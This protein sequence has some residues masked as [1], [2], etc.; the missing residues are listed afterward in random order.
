MTTANDLAE[1]LEINRTTP[2]KAAHGT[3]V[4]GSI[5]GHTFQVLVFEDH[6]E[7]ED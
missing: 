2:R 1:S 5:A 4:S 7:S 3:W 6:A